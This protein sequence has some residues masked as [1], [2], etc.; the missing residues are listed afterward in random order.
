[1]FPVPVSSV[2]CRLPLERVYPEGAHLSFVKG[3]QKQKE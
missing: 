2:G 1:M 3:A